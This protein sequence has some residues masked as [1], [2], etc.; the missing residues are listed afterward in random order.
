MA[1][2]C[3]GD[4]WNVSRGTARVGEIEELASAVLAAGSSLVLATDSAAIAEHAAKLGLM[5]REAVAEIRGDAARDISDEPGQAAGGTAE[6][7]P[8][9]A[10]HDILSSEAASSPQNIVV[11]PSRDS[12]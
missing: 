2:S 10:L 8:Q 5:A 6:P 1:Q 4:I 3:S 11:E 12:G 9:E 7:V